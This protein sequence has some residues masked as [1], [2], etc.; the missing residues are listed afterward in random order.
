MGRNAFKD[1]LCF[2]RTDDHETRLQRRLPDKLATIR[3]IWKIFTK[4][5]QNCLVP[6]SPVCLAEQP[7][8]FRERCVFRVYTKS[9]PDRY[10]IK[11]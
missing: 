9:K 2:I 1:I 3:E 4:N 7:V 6:E 11:I 10:G 5:Y 8:D